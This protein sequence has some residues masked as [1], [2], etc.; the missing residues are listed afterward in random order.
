MTYSL[1]P[2][3]FQEIGAQFLASHQN[4]LLADEQG[5]GKTVQAILAI[6]NRGMSKVLIVCKAGLKLNWE[7]ELK[8]WLEDKSLKIQVL[9]GTKDKLRSQ[10]DI[11]IVNYDLIAISK[12]IYEQIVSR[13]YHVGVFDEAHYLKGR[14]TKR[15]KAI[16]LKHGVAAHCMTRW[17]MTGTPV[18]NRPEELYP[19]L[20]SCAPEVI[21]PYTSFE[22]FAR[23]FCDAWWDGFQLVSKGA[24]STEELN[25]RL[26]K[27]FML[28][29]LKK[30]VLTELPDKTYQLISVPPANAHIAELSTKEFSWGKNEA[31]KGF[32]ESGV[33]H[34][35][36]LRHQLALSKVERAAAHIE[37]LL[38]ENS[39]VVVFAYHRDVI[40]ELNQKLCHYGVHAITGNTP[41][42]MRQI[43]VTNFQEDPKKRIFLGQFQ[44]A[45]DG[46]TLTAASTAVFVE[47]S[48]TPG[49]I[50]QAADRIHRIGQKKAV[51][52]QFLVIERS[53][54]EHML[55]IAI[56]KR[57]TIKEIIDG[58][59][60][61][62]GVA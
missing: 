27:D 36:I 46:I 44:A 59:N 3:P 45:G 52:I 12:N 9:S 5:L 61:T 49:E 15:T 34:I 17:F 2:Y 26:T 33:D 4:A 25:R 23:K 22:S 20:K 60:K 28:R 1:K 7:I 32:S 56:D 48:W 21:Y 6:N 42:I 50:E 58:D 47:S 14:T 8:R 37:D 39:K 13:T 31:R 19:I 10:T 40:S 43:Y 24:S 55:R 51:L 11:V 57:H 29:R 30:D 54:E 38:L 53:L 35:A 41:N 18:L 62:G 16:L